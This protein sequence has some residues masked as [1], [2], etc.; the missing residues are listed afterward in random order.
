MGISKQHDIHRW[1]APELFKV[2]SGFKKRKKVLAISFGKC[3]QLKGKSCM[4]TQL[5]I[6]REIEHSR[7]K[8]NALCFW[9]STNQ[10]KIILKS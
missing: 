10:G 8:L 5:P 4:D 9:R 2:Q 6:K 1:R 3:G 7:T